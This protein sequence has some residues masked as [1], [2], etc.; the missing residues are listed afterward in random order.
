MSK[1]C[2]MQTRKNRRGYDEY[3]VE[4][5]HLKL[6]DLKAN[7]KFLKNIYLEKSNANTTEI[8]VED[9]FFIPKY[10]EP[11]FHVSLLK[12]ETTKKGLRG[13]HTDGG[14]RDPNGKKEEESL[15]WWSL[16][17]GPEEINDAETRLLEKTFP[18][19]KVEDSEQQKF[20][21]KFATSP[22][23]LETSRLGSFRFTFPLKEVLTAYRD[24]ICSGAEPVMRVYKTVLY[25]QEVMY[26]VLVHSPESNETFSEYPLLKDDPNAVCV[27][28]DG[29]LIWRSEAMCETHWY[30]LNIREDRNQMEARRLPN[31]QFYVWDHVAVALHV[32]N[33]EKVLKFDVNKL[34]Q[35]LKYCEEDNVTYHKDYIDLDVAKD[36]VYNLWPESPGPLEVE[37]S[38]QL[39]YPVTRLKVVLAGSSGEETCSIGNAILGEPIF[40]DSGLHSREVTVDN[41]VV[42]II[43][44]PAF[45]ELQVDEKILN[46]IRLSGPELQAFLLVIKLQNIKAAE[47]QKAVKDFEGIFR[48]KA[49]RCTLILFTHQDQ[50]EPGIKNKLMQKV[51]SGKV[52]NRYR[53][54]NIN[55]AHRDLAHQVSDLLKEVKKMTVDR[56]SSWDTQLP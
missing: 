11:E 12:H 40:K 23:F 29:R 25:K 24:Q 41:L 39:S 30:E 9:T 27:Y 2:T 47:I 56:S 15:I 50:T 21:W 37:R 4:S 54:F 3:F 35:N 49:L 34:R 42:N 53:V 19:V 10:P 32:E 51:L 8:T 26:V 55:H 45:S 43:N 7:A 38:L 36:L 6:E 46:Y 22:A 5:Q 18:G 44:T 16:A 28:R 1:Q 14:F 33:T 17:V 52:G 31:H 48:K 13:I 20:L